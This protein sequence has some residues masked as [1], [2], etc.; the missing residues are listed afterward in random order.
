MTDTFAAVGAAGAAA[1][2]TAALS[3]AVPVTGSSA[4]RG[5]TSKEIYLP[6]SSACRVYVFVAAPGIGV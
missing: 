3:T 1:I 4:L 2:L 6:I 5:V